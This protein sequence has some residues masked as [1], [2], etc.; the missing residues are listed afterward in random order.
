MNI[1]FVYDRINKWGGAERVLLALHKVWPEASIYTAVYDRKR[2]AWA[3]VFDVRTTFLDRVPWAR[4]HH[5]WYPWLTPL[6]FETLSFDEY[7][8]VISITSAEAKNLITKSGTLHICY[9]LTPTRYLWSGYQEY[10]D[11]SKVLPFVA[12]ILRKWDRI[13]SARP[14]YYIA[15]SAR[16][17]QRI[18]EYYKR[19]VVRIITPPVNTDQFQI[20]HDDSQMGERPFLVVSRLVPYKRIDVIIAAFNQ[21]G[22]PL[23]VIG[24]G[25][26]RERLRNLARKNITFIHTH[27]TDEQLVGYYQRCRAFVFA[28]DEDFGLAAIE[29]Q[30]CGRPVIAFGN[31]GIAET[32]I[33]RKTGILFYKQTPNEL[34]RAVRQFTSEFYDSRT[35]RRHA[36][37]FGVEPFAKQMKETVLDLYKKYI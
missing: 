37:S 22:Y 17:S 29:A 35:I 13:A 34:I 7:D 23:I 4:K 2:A 11:S 30:A 33:H 24:T 8:V 32:V 10:A 12:P 1:A 21:L 18:Q 14:D 15:I 19:D 6:A 36:L 31:S 3:Q 9:C 20:G 26:E 25:S 27:L 16:V 28:A 5:E